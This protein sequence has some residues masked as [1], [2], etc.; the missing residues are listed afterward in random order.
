M[1]SSIRSVN[2]QGSRYPLVLSDPVS[3]RVPVER[4]DHPRTVHSG[5]PL[6]N[7]NL[8]VLVRPYVPSERFEMSRRSLLLL[9]PSS[10]LDLSNPSRVPLE[11]PSGRLLFSEKGSSS[12]PKQDLLT[13]L[14]IR[15]QIS[16]ETSCLLVPRPTRSSMTPRKTSI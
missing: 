16:D 2:P 8:P 11:H 10:S 15:R 4:P 12:L 13:T 14:Y 9:H 6:S 5:P 1:C 7:L 3:H